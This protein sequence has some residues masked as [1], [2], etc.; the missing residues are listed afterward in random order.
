MHKYKERAQAHVCIY[1]CVGGW[2]GGGVGGG[3]PVQSVL[4][5]YWAF[6]ESKSPG[7]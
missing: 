5:D 2:G 7:R 3:E 4:T 6:T 1:V